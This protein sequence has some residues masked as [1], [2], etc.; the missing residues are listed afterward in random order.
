MS[1]EMENKNICLKINQLETLRNSLYLTQIMQNQAK[2]NF[3]N[4]LRLRWNLQ[5][6][7]QVWVVLLVF[8]LTGFTVMFIKKPIF[9]LLGISSKKSVTDYIIYLILV[10]PLYQ[11]LL[12]FYGAILGKFSFFWEFEKKFFKRI[13]KRN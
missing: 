4:K 11:I 2:N 9:E 10:L 1:S 13:F 5:N 12:L 7:K 8:A 6:V 3:L